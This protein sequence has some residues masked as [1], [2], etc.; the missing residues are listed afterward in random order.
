MPLNGP[1]TP[2]SPLAI[3]AAFFIAYTVWGSTYLVIRIAVHD[4]P[5]GLLAG[6]RFLLAGLI[7]G[8]IALLRGQPVPTAPRD[9]WAAAVMGVLLVVIGNGFVTWAEQWVPSNQAAV[10]IASGAFWTAWLGTFG[11]RGVPLSGQARLGLAIGFAGVLLM[12]W[13]EGRIDPEIFIGQLAVVLAPIAWAAGTAYARHQDLGV[14]TLMFAA[15]QMLAGGLMLTLIGIAAGELTRWTWTV[16]GIGGLAYLTLFGSCLAYGS[17]VWLIGKTTPARLG[18][19]AY[20]NPVIAALLGWWILDET[21]TAAQIT[22]AAIIV[23]GVMLVSLR[24][25]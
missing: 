17:Y 20:V 7:L 3:A 10:I 6:V 11:P 25:R 5:P 15:M 9:W 14:S 22:G 21:L 8:A 24:S 2:V 13:P 1:A 23:A 19:I 4:L 12:V 16:P 18:T